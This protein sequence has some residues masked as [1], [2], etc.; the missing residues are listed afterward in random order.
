MIKSI[1]RRRFERKQR[2]QRS[3]SQE[4]L[5][6]RQ[7]LFGTPLGQFVDAAYQDVLLRPA[8]AGGLEYWTDRLG[9]NSITRGAVANSILISGEHAQA[10]VS[11]LYNDVLG[12]PADPAGLS[13]WAGAIQTGTSELDVEAGFLGSAE[14]FQKAGG[15]NETFIAAAYRDILGRV[16][17]PSETSF[18]L[19]Q[20]NVISREQ[21][22]RNVIYSP[23]HLSQEV[24]AWYQTYLHRSPDSGGLAYWTGLLGAGT[25]PNSIQTG[26]IASPEYYERETAPAIR[27]PGAAGS[28][29]E[30]KIH[31]GGRTDLHS[32][33]GLFVVENDAGIV[34]GLA[35]SQPD[36][37]QTI[38]ASATR[39][40]IF[41]SDQAPTNTSVDP[42]TLPNST[43]LNLPAGAL[44][45]I[46]LVQDGS[47]ADALP[48]TPRA[49]RPPVYVSFP[50]GNGDSFDHYRYGNYVIVGIEDLTGGGDKDFDD[51]VL[52]FEFPKDT[53]T[54]PVNQPPAIEPI[55]N[56]SIPE[57][58]AMQLQVAATDPDGP[59]SAIRYSVDAASANL[60]MAIDAVSGLLTWT[61]N[62]AQGPGTYAVTV[63]AT[64]GGS[65]AASSERTFSINVTEVNRPPVLVDIASRT[66]S[67]GTNVA[68]TASATDP[69]LPANTL[70]Y[71]L[72]NGPA[73][74]TI[75]SATG[76][77]QWTPTEAQN[78]ETYTMTVRV[79]DQGNPAA[80][81][82]TTFGI[83]VED[84]SFASD[85]EVWTSFEDGG[86]ASGKGTTTVEEMLGTI[87][88]G[89]SF[90]V[91]MERTIA[92][93]SV[94]SQLR[95]SVVSSVFDTSATG[96]I[97]DAFEAALVDD[98]GRPVVL[99][100]AAGRDAFFNL[101]EGIP[102]AMGPGVTFDGSTAIVDLSGVTVTSARLVFRLVNN[103]EDRASTVALTCVQVEA[104]ATPLRAAPLTAPA[105]GS[106]NGGSQSGS[107]GS[108]AE[109]QVGPALP[110]GVLPR[111]AP[112]NGS[113]NGGAS[114]ATPAPTAVTAQ[115]DLLPVSAFSIDNRG[116]DFWVGFADNLLEGGN[117]ATKT[118][119]ITGD[120]ATTGTVSVPGLGFSEDFAV[121]PG[122]VT[123]IVLPTLVEV[124]SLFD[125]QDLG[126]H[127]VADEEV[128]VYGLNR[129]Q[130]TTDAYLALPTESLGTEY[131]NLTYRNDGYF[132]A[133]IA[134]TQ[135][136]LVG[137][138]DDTHVTIA[139]GQYSIPTANSSVN[140]VG[141]ANN[142][143]FNIGNG[144]DS[145]LF[146]V[147]TAGNYKLTV[148]PPTLGYA[149]TYQF[150]ILDLA[151]N[152]TALAIGATASG[153][154]PT[155]QETVAYRFA[156]AAGQ[157]VLIDGQNPAY[158]PNLDYRLLSPSGVLLTQTG[159]ESNSEILTLAE[160]GDYYVLVSGAVNMPATFQ[161]RVHDVDDATPMALGSVISG[162]M[163]ANARRTDLFEFNGTVGQQVAFDGQSLG[164]GT[165]VVVYAPGGAMVAN[166]V[167]ADD[168]YPVTLPTSGTYTITVDGRIPGEDYRF[169]V[170]DLSG[171]TP[172][173]FDT[174]VNAASVND[175]ELGVFAFNG[176]AGAAIQFDAL[177]ALGQD[178]QVF[179]PANTQLFTGRTNVD[180][181][182]WTLPVTG[183]YVMYVQ[184]NATGPTA[185]PFRLL[186]LA[187]ATEYTLG[188][189][190]TGNLGAF[191]SRAYRF[192]LAAGMP[193]YYDG[194]DGDFD[195]VRARVTSPAGELI[196]SFFNAD[197]DS[198]IVYSTT[199]GDGYLFVSND[200]A[201]A[202]NYGLVL[203]DLSAAPVL[204]LNTD[205]TAN[206]PTG[207]ETA[208]YRV[209]AAVGDRLIYDG[210]VG[211]GSIPVRLIGPNGQAIYQANSNGDSPVTTILDEGSHYLLVLGGV[212]G[213]TSVQFRMHD[214][215]AAPALPLGVDTPVSFTPGNGAAAYTFNGTAGQRLSLDNLSVA[216]PGSG[217]SSLVAPNGTTVVTRNIEVDFTADI[218]QTG[219]YALVF[220]GN[221]SQASVQAT[222]RATLT[223]PGVVAPSG[224]GTTQTLSI[225]AGQ[226][227]TYQFTS[228][229][230]RVAYL[231]SLNTAN[232]NLRVELRDPSGV[233]LVS[234]NDF[235]D[236]G[237]I[238]LP[239]AGT[240]SVVLTG[241]SPSQTGNYKFRVLDLNSAPALTFDTLNE[242]TTGPFEAAAYQFTSAVGDE[243][244]YNGVD[245]D[246][247]NV[248]ALVVLQSG[249]RAAQLNADGESRIGP[250]NEAGTSFVVLQN[251]QNAS[252]DYRFR[253]LETGHAPT[254]TLG[255]ETTGTF[256][257][258]TETIQYQFQGTAGER[259]L[260]DGLEGDVDNVSA[261]LL[262][263]G[264]SIL[265]S[266]NAD[267]QTAPTVLT[268][269]GTYTL[270]LQ[271]NTTAGA[272]Y[273]FRLLN[274]NAPTAIDVGD[275]VT[276]N[277]GANGREVSYFSFEGTTGQQIFYDALDGDFDGTFASIRDP[278]N[279]ELR[280]ANGD[281]D[282][283]VLSLTV[284]GTYQVIMYGSTP[285]ADFAFVLRDLADAAP[286]AVNAEVTGQTSPGRDTV[287]YT[288]DAVAGQTLY[289]N[290]LDND[291]DATQVF[292]QN[293]K[294][295]TVLQRNSSAE[296]GLFTANATG[297]YYVFLVGR[298]DAAEDYRFAIRDVSGATTI[299]YGDE[300]AGTLALGTNHVVYRFDGAAGQ[301]IYFDGLDTDSDAVNARILSPTGV[302]YRHLNADDNSGVFSLGETGAHY[303]IVEGNAAAGADYRFQLLDVDAAP[304]LTYG[305]DISATL[306][307]GREVQ[308]YRVPGVPGNA[309]L[310]DSLGG[311][312]GNASWILFDPANRQVVG[313]DQTVD[314]TST[315]LYHGDY[316]LVVSGNALAPVNYSF[317][318]TSTT[319]PSAPLTGFG[320][321]QT[322]EL[323]INESA[324]FNFSAP[325]GALLYLDVLQ[326]TF[327]VPT[328]TITLNAGQTY[329]VRDALG[330]NDLTGTVITADK[331]VA[332]Y[333]SHLCGFVPDFTGFCDHLVEQL[334]PTDAWG[335][336][337]VTVPLAT[338]LN[339][340]TFRFLAQD[341]DTEVR[342]NGALVATLD[343]GEF[344][345]RVLTVASEISATRPILVAQYS[346]GS[347]F[348]NVTSDPFMV[349]LPPYEQFLSNY[350]VTTPATGFPINYVNVVASAADVGL[351][352]LDGMPIAA[353]L[354]SAIGASGFFGA[355][356]AVELGSHT[357]AGPS[358][359]GLTVYGYSNF[360]SYGYVGGQ[361]LAPVAAAASLDVTVQQSVVP[362]GSEAVVRATVRDDQGAPLAGVR[363]DFAVAGANPQ[364]A[365]AF[366]DDDGVATLRYVGTVDGLDTIDA[367]VS[368]LVDTATITWGAA[369]GGPSIS[370][371]TPEEGAEIAAGT[372]VAV[373]GLAEADR[374]FASVILVTVNG[375]PVEA[376]DAAGNFFVRLAV[377]PGDNVY[378][379]EVTDSRDQ[380]ARTTLVL[381]GEQR[382]AGDVAFDLLSNVSAS[383]APQYARTSLKEDEDTLFADI[384]IRNDGQY[385]ADAPL[386]VAITNLSDPTVRVL[387]ADGY[388]PDGA[389]YYDFTGLV[390]GGTLAPRSATGF[391]AAAFSAPGR[392]QF[393][394]DLKFFGKLNTAPAFATTPVVDG[395][396]GRSYRY[397]AFA[398]DDDGDTVAY[399]L[400]VAPEGMLIDSATGAIDWLPEADDRGVHEV[401]VLADDGR[402]GT[403]EQ[404]FLVMVVTPPPNRPPVFSTLPVVS[405]ESEAAYRYD[406]DA[407]D[408][409]GD[410]LVFTLTTAP[411]GM[412]IDD[413]TGVI[414][415]TPGAGQLGDFNVAVLV[416]DGA[417][418]VATQQYVVCVQPSSSNYAPVITSAAELFATGDYEYQ[419]QALDANGDALA[420]SLEVAPAGMTINP[421]TGL[422]TWATTPTDER[423]HDVAVRVVDGRGGSDTQTFT[424]TVNDNV[425]PTFTTAPVTAA[426]VGV[427]YVYD[428]NAVDADAINY[429]LAQ[430]PSGMTIDAANG[431][432]QW[433][434]GATHF[435][436][437]RVVVEANDGRGGKTQQAFV[438]QLANGL[439]LAGN[440]APKFI[441]TAPTSGAAR[442]VYRYN[443]VAIDPNG[444]P[445]TYDLA[446]A[447]AGMAIDPATGAIAWTP[448]AEQVGVQQFVVRAKDNQ[449]GVTL[450]SVS[451]TIGAAN[452]APVFSSTAGTQAVVGAA[453][454]Y[455]VAAQDADGDTLSFTLIDGPDDATLGEVFG[456]PNRGILVWFPDAAGPESFTIEVR[457]GQGGTAT[458]QFVVTAVATAP[459]HEPEITT[460]PRASIPL[461]RTWFYLPEA[462]DEDHDRLLYA[463][464]EGPAAMSI[465][466]V[467]GQLIW[468][469]NAV[470]V[471]QV[472]LRVSDGRGGEM[473]QA[474]E[475]EVT[476]EE[477]N[478]A[479]TIVSVPLT[480]AVV[481]DSEFRYHARAVDPDHDPV[482]WSLVDGP[483]G[484]S[485]DPLSGEVRW[486]PRADQ[487][488]AQTIVIQV[489][490]PFLASATQTIHVVATCCNQPPAILSRPVTTANADARYIYGVR[491]ID[492]ENATLTYSLVDAPSGMTIDAATG[493]IRWTPTVAQLGVADV[494]VRVTDASG[495]SAE[496]AYAIDVTQVIPDLAPIFRSRAVF[497]A[498]VG[499]PY[500]YEAEAV[501]PE[502]TLVTY[503]LL[504][505]PAGMTIDPNSGLIA[506]MPAAA[507][508]GPHVVIVA[509]DDAAGNRGQQRYALLAR[510]NQ[511]PEIVSEAPT[512]ISAGAV[513]LYDVQV[514]DPENDPITFTLLEAPEGMTIDALGRIAWTTAL[515]NLGTHAVTVQAA[516]AH[517]LVDTQTF[518]LTVAPDTIAP[519]VSVTLSSPRVAIGSPVVI[520]VQ[521]M[522]DV[523]IAHLALTI[524]GQP[525]TLSE[526]GT[527]I[528]TPDAPGQLNVV[529]TATDAAGNVGQGNA[530]LRAFDPADTDGPLV[531][532]TSPSDGTVVTRITEVFGTVSDANLLS[533]RVEYARADLVDVNDPTADDPD[534]KLIVE[535]STSVVN[536]TL[537]AFDPTM[538]LND[539]YVVR[540][541]AEDSSGNL[542]ARTVALSIDGDL[543]LGEF[544]I[545]FVDLAVPV[546]GIPITVRRTYDTRQAG[547]SGDFGFGWTLDLQNGQV[548]ESVPVSDLELQGLYFGANPFEFGTRVFIT[549]PDGRR[550][551]FTFEP[552]PQF[553]LFGGGYWLPAFRPDPGVYDTLEVDPTP[554][555]LR[556]DGTFGQ[557][558]VGF[559]YN[560]SVYRLTSR[561][562]TVYQYDQFF[563]LQ[564]VT[565]R[566]GKTLTYSGDR[567]VSSTGKEVRIERD[568]F[569]RIAQI[570]DPA[571]RAIR[572]AYDA[573]GNLV[574]VTDRTGESTKY[575]YHATQA[576]ILVKEIDHAGRATLTAEYDAAGRLIGLAGPHG[577]ASQSISDP[578]AQTELLTDPE[579]H[580]TLVTYDDRGN[581]IASRDPIGGVWN[582]NYDAA[583]NLLSASDPSGNTITREFDDRGN[584]VRMTDP[585][586]GVYLTEYNAFN[587]ITRLTDP[588]G[589]VATYEYDARG[590]LVAMINPA[591][592]RSELEV[593][594]EGRTIS[595]TDVMG[596]VTRLVYEE[597][598]QPT[599]QIFADGT[600]RRVEYNSS[601][602]VTREIDENGHATDYTY[603]AEGRLVKI[604]DAIGR[605]TTM[606]YDGDELA[607]STD[608]LGVVTRYERD[609]AKRIV[610]L[611]RNAA[612]T[613]TLV[614]INA[615]E[616][617]PESV[618]QFEYNDN[619]QVVAEI[620][621]IGGRT[622]YT[623]DDRALLATI[624]DALGY[625]TRLEY[626]PAGNLSK[627]TDGR[628]NAVIYRYDAMNRLIEQEDA[629]GFVQKYTY[630][631]L[632][633]QTSYTDQLGRMSTFEYDAFNR[634]VKA[635]DPLGAVQR[636]AFDAHGNAV[637]Y[638]NPNG[639][640]SH[641]EYDARHRMT[642]LTDALGQAITYTYDAAGNRETIADKL[643][644]TWTYTY[645]AANRLISTLD[646]LGGVED[647]EYDALDRMVTQ[648]DV[649]GRTQRW[650][651]NELGDTTSYE[652]AAGS[653]THFT[654]DLAGNRLTLTD[655]LNQTTTYVR[656]LLGQV[657]QVIDPLGHSTFT[658][659]D[660]VGNTVKFTDRNGNVRQFVFDAL[661]R[662]TIER[663][664]TGLTTVREIDYGFNA[665]G[666]FTSISEPDSTYAFEYD[667]RGRLT[668]SDNAGT[669]GVPHVVLDFDRDLVGNILDV[670]SSIGIGIHSTYDATNVLT[671]LTWDG[672]S[673]DASVQFA[674]DARGMVTGVER[675]RDLSGLQPAGTST[676]A[677]DAKGRLTALEHRSAAD[678]V[679]AKYD[680]TYDLAGQM[681]TADDQLDAITYD[682]DLLGQLTSADRTANPDETYTYDE[683]G[684][685]EG[686]DIEV[687]AGNRLA[688]DDRFDY[689]YDN[690]GDLILRSERATG[691]TTEFEYD[692]RGRLVSVVQKDS[693]GAVLHT[694]VNRY[695]A[696][697]RRIAQTVDGLTRYTVYDHERAFAD[698]AEDGSLEAAYLFAPGADNILARATDDGLAWYLADQQG[699][700]RD[701][702]DSTGATLDHIDY[703]SFGAVLAETNPA[704][705]DRFKFTGREYDATTGLYYYRARY[706][707]P[708]AGRFISEDPLGFNAGDP[709][710]YRYV[711]NSPQNASD[712][713]GTTSMVEYSLNVAGTLGGRAGLI[714]TLATFGGNEPYTLTIA[715]SAEGIRLGVDGGVTL[716]HGGS[717]VGVGLHG[718][719]VS[720]TGSTQIS[721]P[722]GP[723]TISGTASS[724]LP[725]AKGDF[726]FYFTSTSESPVFLARFSE[727]AFGLAAIELE[728]FA[729][730][731]DA[732]DSET[733]VT[734]RI[735]EGTL[736]AHAAAT[737]S[738]NDCEDP[739]NVWQFV[740][741]G[742]PV[743]TGDQLH[744]LGGGKGN[745]GGNVVNLRT[746][747]TWT[748]T[749]AWKPMN[750]F[751]GWTIIQF[752]GRPDGTLSGG[753]TAGDMAMA[754]IT[755]GAQ[756]DPTFC[757]ICYFG[758][759]STISLLQ[760][761]G[762][763]GPMFGPTGP[764]ARGKDS[765]T[766]FKGNLIG[767]GQD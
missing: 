638:V 119:F 381:K 255:A 553:S 17:G 286:L 256:P 609:E 416:D 169:R 578:D 357:L 430:G 217:S 222:F 390:T 680:Y 238:T 700:V 285:N 722:L 720:V 724:Q 631:A 483:E 626:D 468:T 292:I 61:P 215:D 330:S 660:A 511:A 35:P 522:D 20:L 23:E 415:W 153:S 363:V 301:R 530:L 28:T 352:E 647:Y 179:G 436:Q 727:A 501:D 640:S 575:E 745:A 327:E 736:T 536:D 597:G 278:F 202:A 741:V 628:G 342:V 8:E 593:D 204:P 133:F 223:T 489:V 528:F 389:P 523:G 322:A 208:I 574:E 697:D 209:D 688:A 534:W 267:F 418:G 115:N 738:P 1:A 662:T 757:S 663:W 12:R 525:V 684:N 65:P 316:V 566:N 616:D 105:T 362:I 370:I 524:N 56:K 319:L 305:V 220:S 185:F 178:F 102:A 210:R 756:G 532:I 509:A 706:Y 515:A 338:R 3:L 154:L 59:A 226:S 16:A 283:G 758:N 420:Y 433:T 287:M 114:A 162:T 601:G 682:Y 9:A 282:S 175:R 646:P 100:F 340:D 590:N 266:L 445:V 348:D 49:Q 284:D 466:P 464:D 729:E 559:P 192:D 668:Q 635:I 602:Q 441:T 625:V 237:P 568:S 53:T 629:F 229:A 364:T 60:G 386:F 401:I 262:G 97:R 26:F 98:Q 388:T 240:Y 124:E 42:T 135:L 356:V 271:A 191:E 493:V 373:A 75:N 10:T 299:D 198:G 318:A 293:A 573:Q 580:A 280:G 203:S 55:A 298:T 717:S 759:G 64:D 572:Y 139:P 129:A 692:H 303:V 382:A 131:I 148:T 314:F 406:A 703:D 613:T 95:F 544:A 475:I 600:R 302:T 32:E 400:P 494:R 653:L 121:N 437:E 753:L 337:F 182:V 308:V 518:T 439:S 251:N 328:H 27:V 392:T 88:E 219:Q 249:V 211:S 80:T 71:T 674:H 106:G 343:R 488:G 246:F 426:T 345:E 514:D 763:G 264:N 41:S 143:I 70:L 87:V 130:S 89:D 158:V 294:F 275:T 48:P 109:T 4:R 712:P 132:L 123:A 259:V 481:T 721:T 739:P 84:C 324:T 247:D 188:A 508:A 485:I 576:H 350:T 269:T 57:Q 639:E 428:V 588:L 451:V 177:G 748:A 497:R 431:V 484:V 108:S 725:T 762:G 714:N 335:R 710:L 427:L 506:W 67:S 495:A 754:L 620:S 368:N 232:Q 709:N 624:T 577:S 213:A 231:D 649:L 134:G 145:N 633:N 297:R 309:V 159:L 152:S 189:T 147:D 174:V 242:G 111:S 76:A 412:T 605:V 606:T 519:R 387:D 643:G 644:E 24:N 516:D 695:D 118:L 99:P 537:G 233:T 234:T 7:L 21:V 612:P 730:Y 666:D 199:G 13:Y 341:D 470:G 366:T 236:Q 183:T 218:T 346:N 252:P 92:I 726:T 676:M 503:S 678:A 11:E 180:S 206:L 380:T 702:V 690:N 410:A 94:A 336:E 295:Q 156:G 548:R 594:A 505:A 31:W 467:T 651:Y 531:E 502:G 707:D 538:L 190:A 361:S 480:S 705:G 746:G 656:D 375:Q 545:S 533:Y 473:S 216:S 405:A 459:N 170:V 419:V 165:D 567:I 474:F 654:S 140:W 435:A 457:D 351:I 715:G 414:T 307:P 742:A 239:S 290:G 46:Y 546:A 686:D 642:K 670:T 272:D 443:A 312:G 461:G 403:T 617:A 77:F 671:G 472:T 751:P 589:R 604:V 334:P 657:V 719:T 486:T 279:N 101:T 52:R 374:P 235:T 81:D 478:G 296:D 627:I 764:A 103:D 504:S 542:T 85:P 421:A 693:A 713:L 554:L 329:L 735:E 186:D 404:R 637:E 652:D 698:F 354:F 425:A 733:L 641:A 39:Q 36:Y 527:A 458:Q 456:V 394:Y 512:T 413:A 630:D 744:R 490:D 586:G 760:Q 560:P 125:V 384:S 355:K 333:G 168:R 469:P 369:I 448:R 526:Q 149:G 166:F 396:A 47:A 645:D 289:F 561:E 117:Q 749:E 395:L 728:L 288:F 442:Q 455:M 306:N 385:P 365:F 126:V 37:T 257:V 25:N 665:V 535:S 58:L 598:T 447:P 704:E 258:G 402:G 22:A 743:L 187:N 171:A 450:Q 677:Y 151:T 622:E 201:V 379:F 138:H 197:S 454:G 564:Q 376:L 661:N 669:A 675:F 569:G 723:V 558:L 510:V 194:L 173:A 476:A 479:P 667:A 142:T 557:H 694:T 353:N 761:M 708:Q 83:T 144:T 326:S 195:N 517:G 432:I 679:L 19:G 276:G 716:T 349:Y 372:T 492:P 72:I 766:Y 205:I 161:F 260:Y 452:H 408:A 141:P 685:R 273:R 570:V 551:G 699:T 423:T 683:L 253:L 6:A 163:P 224:F 2:K 737:K 33:V 323:G 659:Y 15:T 689:D 254:L 38:L 50:S 29:I 755:T 434:P 658:E 332:A 664:M 150:R 591:G 621:P 429:S 610:R 45:G 619:N 230:G 268:A 200:Q 701:I 740:Q 127:V 18:W 34:N 587:Q 393:T 687:T 765:N 399:S 460:E 62:E 207:R 176:V 78:G 718:G 513:Y 116:T 583:G 397:E 104:T 463:L 453:F 107:R 241:S 383:F 311:T 556:A 69:D 227:A 96:G 360:D 339:G 155:G 592:E 541:I 565:D 471:T 300:V 599:E 120:I 79:S 110:P 265:F 157:R 747:G 482:A 122:E 146:V 496:Q 261:T 304:V 491:A 752:H 184:G 731:L 43:T 54:P 562:G 5:E 417:G 250:I 767:V 732:P 407:S 274:L 521:V 438:I 500:E 51:A 520:T 734:A 487:L 228:P 444:D 164:R 711:G 82:E 650:T 128:T 378:E 634:L 66:V 270:V 317:R 245:T 44:M 555:Q 359:F 358:P 603:D 584:V 440:V 618:T 40:V 539:S 112:T 422:I 582:S 63:K 552:T 320:V 377:L 212:N 310:F 248:L 579:G 563:G 614:S 465:D 696:L 391:L 615:V 581:V 611:V 543:K 137:A 411:V 221:G 691:E 73:G 321:N 449:G 571:G 446:L 547:E 277:V 681:L 214:I 244:V 507:Q 540:V 172:V 371:L 529:A 243:Y 263:P 344:H 313:T 462:S 113:T 68:F 93:P 347:T 367:T 409:D 91:G 623:Y 30:T 595:Q 498:T 477:A 585:F 596:N 136:L 549:G 331:P 655:A 499:A 281:L 225:L 86:S 607:T 424:L 673:V 160:S 74:A 90:V 193:L 167:S 636:K 608:A 750:K 315:L 181:N 325:I 672:P 196:G 398:T 632:G 14:Y 648:T 550:R 291:N